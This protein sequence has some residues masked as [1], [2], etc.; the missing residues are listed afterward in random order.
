LPTDLAQ[1]ETLDM[2]TEEYR[3]QLLK[4]IAELHEQLYGP[5]EP[6]EPQSWRDPPENAGTED[7]LAL[8][9]ELEEELAG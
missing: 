5:P 1:Q 2:T 3:Q 7:L 6:D 9:R 4:R 8:I